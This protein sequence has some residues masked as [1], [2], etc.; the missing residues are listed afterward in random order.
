MSTEEQKPKVKLYWLEQSRAQNIL[1]LLEELKIDYE[2][3]VF[4]RNK[5]TMLAPPELSKIHPLGKSPVIEIFPTGS[6]ES[7]K[8]AESGFMTQY[9]CEHFGQD[10]TLIPKKWK[11]GQEGK[12]GGET[13]EWMRCQYFLHYIEGSLL[14]VLTLSLVVSAL[15]SNNVPFIVRPITSVVANRIFSMMVFPNAKKHLAMLEQ[16]LET[17]PGGGNKYICG[18]NLTAA[19]ILLSF[20]LIAAEDRLDSFGNWPGGSAKKAH[21]RVFEYIERLKK[22]PGY[23]RSA[24]K[25][26]EIDGKFEPTISKM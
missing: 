12:I 4:H 24:Q 19:D 10:T 23:E 9:L 3:E 2:V 6:G 26:R 15:K 25:I 22:E 8:L 20:A 18:P 16:Q 21:P 1:W 5:Q 17:A 11:D 7:I 14:P 13:E